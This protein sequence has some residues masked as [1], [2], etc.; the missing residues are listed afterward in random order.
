MTATPFPTASPARFGTPAPMPLAPAAVNTAG[1]GFFG[2]DGLTFEDFLDLINPLQ[3]IP[4]VSTIYRAATGDDISTG[5]RVLGGVLFGGILGLVGALLNVIVA[6]ATGKD[7]GE[8][9]L[10]LFDDAFGDPENAVATNAAPASPPVAH[11][12]NGPESL[13]AVPPQRPAPAV[14][15][16]SHTIEGVPADAAGVDTRNGA[17]GQDLTPVAS[18][19]KTDGD[20]SAMAARFGTQ[21]AAT[22]WVLLVLGQA[23]DKYDTVLQARDTYERLPVAQNR[24]TEKVDTVA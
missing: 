5:A 19:P 15:L 22:G 24:Q 4:I 14:Q 17:P 3:H 9:A 11:P 20:P 21:T 8:H 12:K 6:D 23:L 16:A 10:A 7:I 18:T 13:A 2:D 1:D